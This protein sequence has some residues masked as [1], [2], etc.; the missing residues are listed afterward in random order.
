MSLK[1]VNRHGTH[2][3]Y[4]RGTV[5]GQSISESTGTSDPVRAEEYRAKREAELWKEAVYGK[6]AVVTFA[7][8]VGAYLEDCE[9]SETTKFHL[10]RLLDHFG[11]TRL[12]EIAQ[13]QVDEAYKAILRDGAQASPATKMRGVLT[14]LRAIME[15]AAIRQWCERPAFSTPKIAKRRTNYLQPDEVD[16]LISSAAPHLRPLII[17]LVGTGARLSEALELEWKDVDIRGKRAVVWQKQGNE[18]RIDLPPRVILALL[19]LGHRDGPVFRPKIRRPDALG[20]INDGYV[21]KGRLSGGQIKS[22]WASACRKAMLPGRIRVWTPIGSNTQK[23][24]FLPEITPHDLR[25]TWATWHYCL[26]RDILRLKDDGGWATISI[27]TR[28]AKKMPDEY[29]KDVENWLSQAD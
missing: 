17:F 4:I 6:R 2:R 24:A 9:R 23:S 19:T 7:H 21:S 10:R 3:L 14:P 25:H 26:H 5:S 16:R 22:A 1:I 20:V 27:V 13:P 18:R 12:M 11:T 29:R 28:Y 8:A 15:F